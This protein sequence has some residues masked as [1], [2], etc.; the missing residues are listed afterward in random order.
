MVIKL[1]NLF[2][3]FRFSS[4]SEYLLSTARSQDWC[5]GSESGG[6]GCRMILWKEPI[7]F[8]LGPQFWCHLSEGTVVLRKLLL[9]GA[10]IC[11]IISRANPEVSG[12]RGG[13]HCIEGPVVGGPGCCPSCVELLTPTAFLS[14][15]WAVSM[16]APWSCC[17][18][19]P[20][21][22]GNIAKHVLWTYLLIK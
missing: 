2:L 22:C 20:V 14:G 5:Q 16:E 17:P 13:I 19:W 11:E 18:T 9:S 7:L 3:F 10:V 6:Q 15:L 4:S 1:V 12:K 21:P 8:S